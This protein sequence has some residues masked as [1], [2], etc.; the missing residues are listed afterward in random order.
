MCEIPSNV[1]GAQ[2]SVQSFTASAVDSLIESPFFFHIV[3][4]LSHPLFYPF[5]LLFHRTEHQKDSNR[6]TG[7]SAW[8]LLGF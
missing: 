6:A 3:A 8:L 4:I 7:I 1:P 2:L 5:I